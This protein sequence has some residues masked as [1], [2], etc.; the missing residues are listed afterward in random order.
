MDLIQQLLPVGEGDA[1]ERR[2]LLLAEISQAFAGALDLDI[3]LRNAVE[4]VCAYMDSE[5]GSIFI[6]DD[7]GQSLV[8]RGCAGPVDITGLAIP[9]GRGIV[10]RS[11]RDN[12]VVMVRDVREDPDFSGAVDAKTGFVTR[13]ILCAPLSLQGRTIG[14]IEVINKREGDHLFGPL[15]RTM[16]QV[17]ASAAALAVH[18]ARMAIGLVEQERIR[19][20]LDL[21]RDLQRSLLPAEC[22]EDCA[23]TGVNLPAR[24][25]SGDFFDHFEC[26][27]GRT[28]FS[29]GDVSGKGMNAA[30]LMAKT[31]SLLRCLGKM[32]MRPGELLTRVNNELCDSATRGMFV[33]AVTGIF[34][35]ATGELIWANAGHQPPLLRGRDGQYREYAAA[36]PPLGILPGV[37]YEEQRLFLDEGSFYLFTDGVTE[38]RDFKGGMLELEGFTG[39]LD[40]NAARPARERIDA[41]VKHIQQAPLHDDIT[42]MVLESRPHAGLKLLD[43]LRFVADPAQLKRVRAAVRAAA[44]ASG[45]AEEVTEHLILAVNEACMNVIQHAYKGD[46]AGEIVLEILNNPQRLVFRLKDYAPPVNPA[47]I[48]S[49]D[50]DDIRPGGLGVHFITTL[51]DEHRYLPHSGGIG[52]VLEMVK[53]KTANGAA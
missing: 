23:I 41:V 20:E 6:L 15:D 49:R 10:G 24:E 22:D 35:S 53:Y 16:L 38:G 33:T 30:L 48:K 7:S 50:L 13:S 19:R 45:F 36:A 26:G 43:K 34:N 31:S 3:T 51:M 2:L 42:L 46:A 5:A 39:L 29:L 28:C 44:Q 14:A 9:A 18:N 8:C 21:A 12:V 32:G 4:K 27:E 25:V 11:V 17:L 47:M 1:E 37:E 52:N 40:Q